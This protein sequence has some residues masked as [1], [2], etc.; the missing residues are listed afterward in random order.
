[1]KYSAQ[2]FSLSQASFEVKHS[3]SERA[4]HMKIKLYAIDHM[5]I[6]IHRLYGPLAVLSDMWHIVNALPGD[7]L[8]KFQLL[9]TYMCVCARQMLAGWAD[10]QL[11]WQTLLLHMHASASSNNKSNKA[12]AYAEWQKC[13]CYKMANWYCSP[14]SNCCSCYSAVAAS[15]R[16]QLTADRKRRLTVSAAGHSLTHCTLHQ[17]CC[18]VNSCCYPTVWY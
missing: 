12:F 7:H 4:G 3:S 1:M 6:S 13:C 14:I 10:Q 15:C 9:A 18:C 16:L 17:Q 8:H 2:M 5:H 11:C